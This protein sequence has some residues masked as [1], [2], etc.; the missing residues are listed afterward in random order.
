MKQ[1]SEEATALARVAE[2]AREVQAASAALEQHFDETTGSPP[3]TLQL[4]RFAAAMQELKEA[5]E[6]FDAL[7]GKSS[8]PSV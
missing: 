7:L 5:R 3:S 4:A 6:S 1:Q 8:G 2:A